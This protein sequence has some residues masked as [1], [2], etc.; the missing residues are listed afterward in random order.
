MKNWLQKLCINFLVKNL[1]NT[2]STNGILGEKVDKDKD[3]RL[4][5]RV[6][7]GG[8]PLDKATVDILREEANRFSKSSLWMLVG[9]AV[10]NGCNERMFYKGMTDQDLLAG[11]MGLWVLKTIDEVINGIKKM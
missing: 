6:Y 2:I 10:K 11:K 5:K 3:G 1:Y 9:N 8:K 4:V 7:L